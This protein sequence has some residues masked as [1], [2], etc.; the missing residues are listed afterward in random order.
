MMWGPIGA[1]SPASDPGPTAEP[2]LGAGQGTRPTSL[3]PTL[4]AYWARLNR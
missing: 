1:P 2:G 3:G 4:F